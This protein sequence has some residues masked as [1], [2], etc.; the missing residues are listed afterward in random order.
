MK[1]IYANLKEE[2]ESFLTATLPEAILCT[3]EIGVKARSAAFELVVAM[4]E[5][6]ITW[7]ADVEES[8]KG[9]LIY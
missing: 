6:Y 3:K 5:A 1:H 4:S 9:F 2:N 7:N 8:G